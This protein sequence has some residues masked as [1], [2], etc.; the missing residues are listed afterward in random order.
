MLEQYNNNVIIFL[1]LI[2]YSMILTPLYLHNHFMQL[3]FHLY[4]VKDYRVM[5][6]KKEKQKISGSY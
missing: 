3:R 1:T 5:W 2:L 4:E 6:E